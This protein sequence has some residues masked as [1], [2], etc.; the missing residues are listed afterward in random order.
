M[1]PEGQMGLGLGEQPNAGMEL[2]IARRWLILRAGCEEPVW[3]FSFSPFGTEPQHPYSPFWV[4]G[5][6]LKDPIPTLQLF[7]KDALTVRNFIWPLP[8]LI[9]NNDHHKDD[10]FSQNSQKRPERGQVAPYPEDGDNG[11]GTDGVGSITFILARV[12]CD[13]ETHDAQLSVILLVDNEEAA[14]GIDNVLLRGR[15]SKNTQRSVEVNSCPR[16]GSKV[17]PS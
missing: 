8:L 1:G 4:L 5:N 17:L 16:Q 11:G 2:I 7:C 9:H 6:H 13:L 10:D 3:E 14:G 15:E 12:F